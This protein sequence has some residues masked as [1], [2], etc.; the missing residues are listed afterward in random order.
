MTLFTHAIPYG[1][2]Y[3]DLNIGTY[4]RLVVVAVVVVVVAAGAVVVV[5][6]LFLFEFFFFF[7][8]RQVTFW[9][10]TLRKGIQWSDLLSVSRQSVSTLLKRFYI[11]KVSPLPPPPPPPPK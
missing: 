6:L 1:C 4:G 9:L 5:V 10:R 2:V 7:L 3:V 11:G 8:N